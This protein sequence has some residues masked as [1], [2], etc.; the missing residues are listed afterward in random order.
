MDIASINA[1]V[2]SL[3]TAKDIAQGIL[4]LKST[5][6]IQGRV[7][8]LQTVILDAQGKALEAQDEQFELKRRLSDLASSL[9]ALRSR[10]EFIAMLERK[11]S[12]YFAEGDAD[13]FCPKCVEADRMAIHLIKTTKLEAR[14]R[15]F[16]CPSC[17]NEFP[18]RA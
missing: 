2:A 9:E 4:T 16:A 3:K 13:P 11:D 7:I 15:I 12:L 8:E 18:L 5:A 14:L 10:E 6:E 1:A 17:K